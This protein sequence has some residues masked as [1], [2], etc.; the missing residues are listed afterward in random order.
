M[1]ATPDAPTCATCYEVIVQVVAAGGFLER[2]SAGKR[3]T[4]GEEAGF[5]WWMD[6]SQTLVHCEDYTGMGG[7]EE[8]TK[9][10]R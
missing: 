8:S 10:G 7:I 2:S 1:D 5:G 3:L 4:R 9:A 6:G